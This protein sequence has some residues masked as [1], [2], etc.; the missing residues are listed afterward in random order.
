M[1]LQLIA[2]ALL[3]FLFGGY[4]VL[5]GFDLG[6]GMLLP[7]LGHSAAERDELRGMMGPFWDGNE[8]WLIV[9]AGATFAT[10]P[11]VYGA[12]L[13]GFYIPLMLVLFS[14]VLRAVSFG[15]HSRTDPLAWVWSA[16]MVVGSFVPAFALGLV[17]GDI[18]GGVGLDQN[19]FVTGSQL[20][21]LGVATGLLAVAAFASQGTS[22]AALFAEGELRTRVLAVRTWANALFAAAAILGATATAAVAPDRFRMV[23][24][25]PIGWLAVLLLAAGLLGAKLAMGQGRD[26][27]AFLWSSA[28]VAALPLIVAVAIFPELLPAHTEAFSLTVANSANSQGTLSILLGI[29]LIGMPI[30]IAYTALVYRTFAARSAAP[31]PDR[32]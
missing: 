9:A 18:V 25:R 19:G 16:G 30:V 28:A 32:S 4:A 5:D 29:A 17:V 20:G 31:Q 2:F 15:F 22:W 12:V 13:S 23:L 11:R 14:L 8:V 10:F 21:P 27:A 24:S 26:R 1:L 6:I 3:V 7:V